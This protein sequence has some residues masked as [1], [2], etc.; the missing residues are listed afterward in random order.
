M[1]GFAEA[2]GGL[3]KE[4]LGHAIGEEA[5]EGSHNFLG[6][7]F[8]S[9]RARVFNQ[10]DV[11][12][13]TMGLLQEHK[14]VQ[15]AAIPE[16]AKQFPGISHND[17][18]SKGKAIADEQVFLKNNSA[19]S[20]IF[21]ISHVK[22][23]PAY[24]QNL[25]DNVAMS[26]REDYHI[27]GHRHQSLTATQGKAA[28]ET[29]PE[30]TKYQDAVKG[31][32]Q[33]VAGLKKGGKTL[34]EA[35]HKEILQSH[36]DKNG[37]KEVPHEYHPDS[38]YTKQGAGER[39]WTNAIYSR[40]SPMIAINHIGTAMNVGLTTQNGALARALADTF[41][42]ATMRERAELFQ[43]S[44]ILGEGVLRDLR[45][46]ELIK[47]GKLTRH[48]PGSV[49]DI[50]A[51]VT[52]TPGFGIER[53][54]QTSLAG[55]ASYHDSISY[56]SRLGKDNYD[57]QAIARLE[58]Y[59]MRPAD[60]ATIKKSGTLTEDQ[61]QRAVYYGV[62]RKIFLDTRFNRSYNSGRNVWT[63][64]GSMYHNYVSAQANLMAS[65]FKFAFKSD[66]RSLG[67]ITKFLTVGGIVFPVMGEGL[68]V[69]EMVARG[70]WSQIPHELDE[71]YKD[72]TFQ[73]G[74]SAISSTYGFASEYIDALSHMG[75][76][77]LS[78]DLM[79]GASRGYLANELLGP[80]L[81]T[82]ARLGGD[83]ASIGKAAATDKNI[84]HAA[85]PL[86]RDLADIS[87]PWGIG[88]AVRHE[89]LPTKR[90]QQ[91]AKSS[92]KLKKMKSIGHFKKLDSL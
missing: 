29:L 85:I 38:D 37:V 59:G 70:Q 62:D 48:L 78:F 74:D 40:F 63:R 43:A 71:D 75:G 66:T 45:E 39:Y 91:N 88:R 64:M 8:R 87:L 26:L 5:A 53:R 44:G 61:L 19:L 46:Q 35:D 81:G 23:G 50:L 18:A 24:T 49:Q 31:Y 20:A 72:I 68:K 67:A 54:W 16:I 33:E 76:F 82:I 34:T 3:A 12:R 32:R 2:L 30:Y 57:K 25:M 17:L 6:E 90:E 1:G 79:Q 11:G 42:P 86:G 69:A 83:V 80:G 84:F 52:S 14:R 73:H 77:G 55:N 7:T 10:N 56:A 15:S 60:L 51:K 13:F 58:Q 92:H 4:G 65:E 47:D 41:N 89:F 28:I 9:T 36:M 27:D 21:K 22:H